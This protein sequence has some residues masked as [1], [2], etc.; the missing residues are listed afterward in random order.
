MIAVTGAN[1]LLGSFITQQLLSIHSE[2]VAV[3]RPDANLEL[4][5]PVNSAI[6]FRHSDVTDLPS[7]QQALA[8]ATTVV[9]VAGV[10][11]F[12][13]AHRDRVYQVN[14]EGTRNVINC[15][16]KLGVKNVIH[17][18]SVAALGRSKESK[19]V[20]ETTR[21]VASNLNTDYAES[22]HLAELEVFRGM[23][24]G[25]QVSMVNPSVILAPVRSGQSSAQLFSYI[26]KGWPFYGDGDLN[27]VDV[28]DVAHL[29]QQLVSQP[30]NGERYI[31]N[32]GTVSLKQMLDGISA[33]LNKPK[34][35]LRIPGALV[36][37]AAWAEEGRA[38]LAGKEPMLTRQSVKLLKEN[39]FFN[40]QKA[41]AELGMRFRTLD[42]TLD[43]CCQV[44]KNN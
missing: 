32:A 22:K 11:S 31:A 5:R 1:G 3:V 9:H 43:W 6:T 23:E 26:E 44:L 19:Q 15:C 8:G 37:A 14:V 42:E 29:V 7:L 35:K 40:N 38:R 13:R 36:A 2:V 33:R 18:S 10:V 39:F 41:I 21:W 20:D 30:R 27:F 12:N 24:E 4:L 28:R 34:P 17:V 16:L 25:L